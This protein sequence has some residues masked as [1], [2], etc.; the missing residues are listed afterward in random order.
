MYGDRLLACQS[1]I[2]A[3]LYS[4]SLA[5]KRDKAMSWRHVLCSGPEKLFACNLTNKLYPFS[6][7]TFLFI[8]HC[9]KEGRGPYF[10]L[11]WD[12]QHNQM[13]TRVKRDQYLMCNKGRCLNIAWLDQCFP[14]QHPEKK[15][16][17]ISSCLLSTAEPKLQ[18]MPFEAFEFHIYQ[19]KE[20]YS[21]P[22]C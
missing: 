13:I 9:V 18:I 8:F 6:W 16:S 5:I 11:L 1:S 4:L 7:Y 19:D 14:Y 21:T 15:P 3:H 2:F 12:M 17:L 20:K 22:V 10:L